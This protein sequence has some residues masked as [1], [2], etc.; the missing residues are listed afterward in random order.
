ME[1]TFKFMGVYSVQTKGQERREK[2]LF[3]VWQVHNNEQVKIHVQEIDKNYRPK[4]KV[5]SIDGT[6]FT[7]FTFE[8]S[9]VALPKTTPE[10][11][12]GLQKAAKPDGHVLKSQS[13][14]FDVDFWRFGQKPQPSAQKISPEAEDQSKELSQISL[15]K[16]LRNDFDEALEQLNE[17][18]ARRGALRFIKTIPQQK[19]IKPRHKHM[20]KDFMTTLRKRE[21]PEIALL[22]A[23]KNVELAPEDDHAH[24]NLARIFCILERYKDAIAHLHKAIELPNKDRE[25]QKIY[26][27]ML[28]YVEKQLRRQ[29][30]PKYYR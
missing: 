8:P 16:T 11:I 12:L 27:K 13:N 20:L 6:T 28:R 7:F 9:I 22:F 14:D 5:Y 21:L 10:E 1:P 23:T 29:Q 25:D 18:H 26:W 15:E 3:F 19:T 30:R 4:S 24:F 17:P 2:E